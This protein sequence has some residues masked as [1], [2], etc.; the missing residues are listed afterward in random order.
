MTNHGFAHAF[1]LLG[2]LSSACGG[3]EEPAPAQATTADD[4]SAP[5]PT[6]ETAPPP[7]EVTQTPTAERVTD[8]EVAAFS[9]LHIELMTLQQQATL[10]VQQGEPPEQVQA[11]VDE[12]VTTLFQN[13]SLTPE[14]YEQIAQRAN[15]NDALRERIERELSA[16]QPSPGGGGAGAGAAP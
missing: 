5:P 6:T 7:R 14:R 15:T 1:A 12:R 9:T 2:I 8:A 4:R 3:A 16:S 10:Q 11:Q 13:S